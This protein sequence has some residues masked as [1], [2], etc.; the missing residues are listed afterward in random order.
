MILV[1]NIIKEYF[2]EY[3]TIEE[4]EKFALFEKL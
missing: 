3:L 1:L 4:T 2:G